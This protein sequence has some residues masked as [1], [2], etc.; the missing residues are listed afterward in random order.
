MYFS[1]HPDLIYAA[2]PDGFIPVSNDVARLI[3]FGRYHA[4]WL[5]R[6]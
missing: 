3:W 4:M 6:R 2:I 1:K 5:I